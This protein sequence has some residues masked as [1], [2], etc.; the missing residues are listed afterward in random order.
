MRRFVA[1]AVTVLLAIGSLVAVQ[2]A[3]ANPLSVSVDGGSKSMYSS[4]TTRK[5]V[6][7]A[8][9]DIF[10]LYTG[11]TGNHVAKS[12]NG[13]VSFSTSSATVSPAVDA[14]IA[15]SS[16]GNLF[17]TYVESGTIKQ[18]KS[19][20]AGA[21]WSAPVTVGTSAQTSVHTAVDREYVYVIPRNG[22]K[23]FSSSD[24]GS[25]W[26]EAS[27]SSTSWAYSDLA[28]DPLTGVIYPFVDRPQVSWFASND[29]GLTFSSE[30]VTGKSVF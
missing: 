21:N 23:V 16:N 5:M 18:R 12:T 1:S 14:E 22:Q 2:A 13:G 9:G 25:T 20:D 19:T 15:V 6:V 10:L 7:D 29:R 28:V 27:L 3:S 4:N 24:N 30:R 11:S 17:V 8:S 26:V